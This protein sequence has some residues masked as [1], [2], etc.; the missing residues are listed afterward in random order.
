MFQGSNFLKW[1]LSFE[2]EKDKFVRTILSSDRFELHNKH[3][4]GNVII[5][6]FRTYK[7]TSNL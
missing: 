7:N 6:L 2:L 4:P 1:Q 5:C 3:T